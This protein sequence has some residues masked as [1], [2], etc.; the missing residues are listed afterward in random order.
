MKKPATRLILFVLFAGFI[1][2]DGAMLSGCAN[3]IPPTGGPRDSIPPVLLEVSPPDSTRGF[4]AGKIT[5]LFN[6]YIELNNALENVIISPTLKNIPVIESRL[7]TLTV[8]IKDTLE[9]NTTYSINFGN[10]IRDINEGN[11]LKDFTYIFS[12]GDHFD[13]LTLSGKV[14]LAETGGTDSTLIVMLHRSQDDSAVVKD[15][16]RYYTRVRPDGSFTFRYLPPGTFSI[17]AL[18]DRGG[19]RQFTSPSQLFAF[20]DKP[21]QTGAGAQPITLYAYREKAE[22]SNQGGTTTT[23]GRPPRIAANQ[24]KVLRI[25]TNIS[26]NQLDLLKDLQITFNTPLKVFDTTKIRFTDDQFNN[27]PHAPFVLDSTRKVV[28]LKHP[29]VGG[30][31]YNII[32]N[33][34]FA[35]DSLGRKLLRDDT[36]NFNARRETEYGSLKLRF[37]NLDM[38]K[39]PVLL[40]V[41]N[42]QVVHTHVF[43]GRDINI[44]LFTPGEYELRLLYDENRNGK[45]DPGEFIGKH[46][47][48]ER[49]VPIPRRLNVKPNWD[50]EVDITL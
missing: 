50:N 43:T 14:I 4:T 25:Q 6:E 29:W 47:Q 8:R 27:L 42:D 1:M 20:A 46:R 3:M 11:E 36:L 39:N 12:T 37:L 13:S 44:R 21:V 34:D 15:R 35:E 16:P 33:K 45:F 22:T 26:N 41:Q 23:G 40:F 7:R 9:P 38:S 10:A 32:V 19:T 24:D 49:V 18:E 31:G 2:A 5:F 48:P 28:T 30:L 17:Y